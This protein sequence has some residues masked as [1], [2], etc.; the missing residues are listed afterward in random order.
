ML[1]TY[2]Y[3]S[4]YEFFTPALDGR[5][6][7][8]TV[9]KQIFMILRF[10]SAFKPILTLLWSGWS[11]FFLRFPIL[12]FFFQVFGDHFNH[13]N[14]NMYHC[15]LMFLSCFFFYLSL[16]T[17]NFIY[18][19]SSSSLLLLLLLLF[20]LYIRVYQKYFHFLLTF[21]LKFILCT[22]LNTMNLLPSSSS[23]H[24]DSTEFP[25]SLSPSIPIIYQSC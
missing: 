13:T 25:D 6:S 9:D 22:D 7:L 16:K 21:N 3:N 23:I 11:R 19:F 14:H 20:L 10:F 8:D 2:C 18:L 24:A 4:L 17:Q 15:S 5:L 1:Q 12:P